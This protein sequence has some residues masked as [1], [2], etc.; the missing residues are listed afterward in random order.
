MKAQVEKPLTVGQQR[1]VWIAESC[2]W[3]TINHIGVVRQ[4]KPNTT[5]SFE[6]PT[7]IV[8]TKPWF[9]DLITLGLRRTQV[10]RGESRSADRPTAPSRTRPPAGIYVQIV[11]HEAQENI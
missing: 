10:N 1:I 2:A 4:L 9:T 8:H 5:F 6:H 3:T 7:G 11:Q